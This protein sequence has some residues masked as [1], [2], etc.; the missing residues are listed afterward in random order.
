MLISTIDNKVV[1]ITVEGGVVSIENIPPDIEVR[2]F[3]YDIDGYNESELELD[4]NGR[5]CVI[6]EYIG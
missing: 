4:N 1:I 2:M 6:T 5:K 3:D